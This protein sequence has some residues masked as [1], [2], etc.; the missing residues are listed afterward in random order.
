MEKLIRDRITHGMVGIMLL[1]VA[2][3][4]CGEAPADA[5]VQTATDAALLFRDPSASGPRLDVYDFDGHAA[6]AVSGPIGTEAQLAG[7]N[8]DSLEELYRGVHPDA[9]SIPAELLALG[10]RLAPA[11]AELRSAPRPSDAT[12]AIVNKSESDFYNAV[13]VTFQQF[14]YR[15]VPLECQWD[16]GMDQQLIFQNPHHILAGDRTYGWNHNS[17]TAKMYWG[18]NAAMAGQITLPAYWWTWMSMT[19]GGPYYAMIYLS[20]GWTGELG[21]THHSRR[22][23]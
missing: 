6:I 18:R 16:T 23:F 7:L 2:A 4:G 11:L 15:Y 19:S 1:G 9:T 3:A 20:G 10:E 22:L 8:A 21:L 17:V 12:P 5:S 13:C 14:P